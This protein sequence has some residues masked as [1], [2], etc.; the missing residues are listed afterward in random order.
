MLHALTIALALL[1]QSKPDPPTPRDLVA[2]IETVVADAIEGAEPS[3]VAI[4]RDKSGKGDE[5]TAVRGRNPAPLP[6]GELMNGLNAFDPDPVSFDYASGVVVGDRGQILTAYHA[7]RGASR[8]QVKAFG[9]EQFEAEI[10]AADPRSDLAVIVP[11]EGPGIVRPKLK[12]IPLGDAS[13]LRK[14]TF[15]LALGNPYNAARD[16]RASASWGILANVAR[17]LEPVSRDDAQ[18]RHFPTLLQLDSK[19]NLGMSGGAVVNLRGELVGLTTGAASV[20]GFDAQAGYAIP[21]DRLGKRA[22]EA[23]IEG[24][25]VEY[26]FLGIGLPLD[27]SNHVDRVKPGTPASEGGL[28]V[29]DEIVAVGPIPVVDSSSLVTAVNAFAPGVPIRLKIVREGKPL[30]KTVVLSKFPLVGEVIAT[31]RPAPWRGLR[32]DYLSMMPN[33][34]FGNILLDAMSRGGVGIV[35]VIPGSPA[36]A[37]GL[38][39]GQIILSV[40]DRPVKT[41]AEF[42]GAVADLKGPVDLATE[43]ERRVTVK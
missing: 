32:V 40:G 2:A 20:S 24:K 5:T 16:G 29:G 34:N 12:P 9:R 14:G 10:I 28:V 23:L 17:R 21:L 7:V 33:A 19:L 36:D 38:R 4:A 41:P 27:R 26:G 37:A 42:A 43:S 31:N 8:L 1:M 18:L 6:V 35:E 15:L 22:L 13:N 39:Q 25:E 3:V 30:E 11:R